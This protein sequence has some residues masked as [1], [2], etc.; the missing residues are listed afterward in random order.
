M[1]ADGWSTLPAELLEKVFEALQAD[2][3]SKPPQ[4]DGLGF[5]KAVAVVRLVCSGWQRIHDLLVSLW[6]GHTDEATILPLR[7]RGGGEHHG[8]DPST[9]G[10]AGAHHVLPRQHV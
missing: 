8:A 7:R 3:G 6:D 5:A 10:S 4:D 2:G 9:G 1:S